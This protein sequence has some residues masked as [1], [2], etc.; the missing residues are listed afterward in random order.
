MENSDSLATHNFTLVGDAEVQYQKQSGANGAFGL[1]DF[2][3]IFLYRGGDSILFEAG[4]DFIL[5]NNANRLGDGTSSAGYTTTV[6]LSFAML[7]YVVNDY[8]TI[9]GGNMLLPL[10]TYSERGAGWLNKIPDQPLPRSL[11]PGNG[12]GVQVRGALPISRIPATPSPTRSSPSTASPRSTAT[13]RSSTAP[14]TVSTSTP[15]AATSA[16]PRTSTPPPAEAPDSGYFHVWGPQHDIEVG[17]SG[18]SSQWDDSGRRHYT[19][20]V[21]DAAIHLGPSVEI[22][23]E[24]IASRIATTDQGLLT[25]SGWWVQAGYKLSGLGADISY[26]DK[27][28]LVGRYD[29]IDDGLQNGLGTI[30]SRATVG[31]VY[32][33]TNT[34]WF[35]GAYEFSTNHG[36]VAN[37]PAGVPIM[38]SS[39]FVFQ[40]SYGF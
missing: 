28:E 23:G 16:T 9:L 29:T 27:I 2:A 6:N 12:V 34:L 31:A 17:V 3:P 1:A 38:P 30:T 18:M 36:A 26:L 7:D 20:G 8:C 14:P 24:Y 32:H 13:E 25:P 33:I 5:A 15:R 39:S 22:K 21:I 10:G 19:A 40:L 11:I 37:A 4:F 35:E